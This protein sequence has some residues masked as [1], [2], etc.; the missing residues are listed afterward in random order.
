MNRNEKAFHDWWCNP[1]RPNVCD[2]SPHDVCKMAF[3]AGQKSIPTS[4]QMRKALEDLLGM[5]D[6]FDA[7]FQ[8]FEEVNQAENILG[9]PISNPQ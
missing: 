2:I 9:I 4:P 3:V 6:D 8:G 5:L 7:G 1:K